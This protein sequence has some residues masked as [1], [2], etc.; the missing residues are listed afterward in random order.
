MIAGGT[1]GTDDLGGGATIVG[2]ECGAGGECFW[3]VGGAGAGDD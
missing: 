2:A 1:G 3:V